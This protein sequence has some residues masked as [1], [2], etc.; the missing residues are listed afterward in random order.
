MGAEATG[1][2]LGSDVPRPRW[3]CRAGKECWRRPNVDHRGRRNS[4][5][6]DWCFTV[7]RR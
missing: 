2:L 7:I 3:E 4:R 1:G 6:S 5:P